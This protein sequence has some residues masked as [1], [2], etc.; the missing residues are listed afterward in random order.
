[1]VERK[2]MLSQ[3]DQPWQTLRRSVEKLELLST[4]P[5]RHKRLPEK[6]KDFDTSWRISTISFAKTVLSYFASVIIELRDF[7]PVK[8]SLH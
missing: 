6:F 4:R 2:G 7:I 5:V 3:R 1:M 8:S